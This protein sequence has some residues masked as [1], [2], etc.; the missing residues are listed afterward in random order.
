MSTNLKHFFLKK[1]TEFFISNFIILS[2]F[3][4]NENSHFNIF[5][6]GNELHKKNLFI[7]EE[8]TRGVVFISSMK[9]LITI[10]SLVFKYDSIRSNI[11]EKHYLIKIE[12]KIIDLTLLN[13]RIPII[14]NMRSIIFS[15]DMIY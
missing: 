12:E 2:C 7:S 10:D 13:I 9:N 5:L 6:S 1:V 15:P 4:S 14:M 8:F 11:Q 3:S